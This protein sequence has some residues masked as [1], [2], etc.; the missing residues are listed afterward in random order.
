MT[1]ILCSNIFY[2]D[3]VLKEDNDTFSIILHEVA[4]E[5]W[6]SLFTNSLC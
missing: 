4:V 2:S 3:H 6:D 5:G 1:D